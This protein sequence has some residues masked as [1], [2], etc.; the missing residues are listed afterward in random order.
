MRNRMI[1][2]LK[3]LAQ[4]LGRTPIITEYRQN[5]TT[6]VKPI[7]NIFGSYPAFCEAAGLPPYITKVA[8]PSK[9]A[10]LDDM[11]SL[12]DKLGHVPSYTEYMEYGTYSVVSVRSIY[13]K[14]SIARRAAGWTLDWS[15]DWSIDDVS[16]ADGHWLSGLTV[17]EGCFRIAYA[18]A[19]NYYPAFSLSQRADRAAVVHRVAQI[20]GLPDRLEYRHKPTNAVARGY[21][22]VVSLHVASVQTMSLHI[23]PFFTVFPLYGPK[24]RDFIITAA[25]THILC[26]KILTRGRHVPYTAKERVSLEW[27][28]IA[29][30]AVKKPTFS[31]TN[32]PTPPINLR[33][34]YIALSG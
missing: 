4:T 6:N 3:I 1:A 13:G 22:D 12:H 7:Y 31:V 8:P 30:A 2:E 33:P 28:Y 26:N 14:W 16:I 11:H 27:A 9:Q 25:A 17:G 18:K 10:F 32:L 29:C 23:I 21:S 20:L 34:L 5:I 24:H 19:N 15:T